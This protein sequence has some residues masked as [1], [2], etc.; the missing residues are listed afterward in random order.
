[1]NDVGDDDLGEIDGERSENSTLWVL[2]DVGD[3]DL[4]ENST[5]VLLVVGLVLDL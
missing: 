4:S 1:L 5:L 2:N 3:G